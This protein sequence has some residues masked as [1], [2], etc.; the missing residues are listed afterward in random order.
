MVEHGCVLGID[1]GYS[2]RKKSTGFCV[3]WWNA[4]TIDWRCQNAGTD[5]NSRKQALHHLLSPDHLDVLAVAIDG[6]L[7][8]QLV[9]DSTTCRLSESLLM[10]G[11]FQ[12]RGKPGATNSGSGPKLHV[13]ATRLAHFILAQ[14]NITSA[15]HL[16]SIYTK[17]IVEAFPNQFLG[18]LCDE[19]IYPQTPHKK[20]KWTD[21]LYPIVRSK[22]EDLVK[23]LLPDRKVNG[24]WN[25]DDHEEIAGLVCALSALC[26][27]A[28][29]FVAVGSDDD[30]YIILPPQVSWGQ[31]EM[32]SVSWA[33]RE[34]RRNLEAVIKHFPTAAVYNNGEK[35]KL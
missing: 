35:W 2:Q 33:E 28:H 32:S 7:R 11:Q 1:V 25:L 14:V 24:D 30:G 3:L 29:Q 34:L 21:T 6:P 20:R 23:S 22:L 8:P 15:T 26:V 9:G 19:V 13:G 17:T 31:S 10:R 18:V 16:P 27:A 5:D 12:K 4:N